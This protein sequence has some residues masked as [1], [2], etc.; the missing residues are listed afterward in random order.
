MT[1][2]TFLETL[3][4]IGIL[5]SPAHATRIAQDVI[6]HA[7]LADS[8][9]ETTYTIPKAITRMSALT[10]QG[11][12]STRCQAGSINVSASCSTFFLR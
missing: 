8:G 5:D 12:A 10:C 11:D 7:D 3:E 4:A 2:F 6:L 1:S 9:K